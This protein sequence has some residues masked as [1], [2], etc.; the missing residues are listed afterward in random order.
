MVYGMETMKMER[1]VFY[2]SQSGIDNSGEKLVTREL[3]EMIDKT[4]EV[5]GKLVLEKGIYLT[6]SLFLKSNMELHF[7]DGAV[8][9]GTTDESQYPVIPTRVAGIEMNW[10]PGILNCNH[11]SHVTI[12]GNG[13][14]DGQGEYW[15][16]KYWGEDQTG[17]MRREYDA[18]GLRWACDYD[19]MRVRNVV[20]MDSSDIEL[21]DITSMRSGFWNIHVCYS[22]RVHIDGIKITAC[23]HNS[24][25]TDGIDID[26]CSHVLVEHCETL[27]NDDSICIK[28]GRDGDGLRVNRPCHDIE[29]RDCKILAGFGVTIGSE[30]SG[31][32]YNITLKNLEYDG[33][34]C[35]FR[36]KS[37]IARRG[38]IKDVTVDGLTMHN[39]K[40][41]FHML[42]NWNP[43]YSYCELPE[44]YEGEVSDS[45]K[46]LLTPISDEV[47]MTAVSDITIQNVKAWN[48][49]DYTGISRAFH[50][51]G[52]AEQPIRRIHFKNMQLECKEFGVINY[53]EQISMEQVTV[54]VSGAH[55]AKNDE[56]D[57]R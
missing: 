32:V 50:I 31:G 48:D 55:D 34:D 54:S 51:E 46:A 15:W 1:E 29:V 56:Y 13:N 24:P 43:A 10:Y 9:L 6:A 33:T 35:G 30:V 21:R 3:Q 22:T 38:Y 47:P 49:K 8:L 41:P 2:T 42:L 45:W 27:C 19:C 37:S 53:T 16:R 17:G 4:A 5:S 52:F 44:G 14:I 26:S 40:Y 20:I 36:I 11:Q 23:G 7:E 12:S 57:N 39:V 18:K 28:S 25:S